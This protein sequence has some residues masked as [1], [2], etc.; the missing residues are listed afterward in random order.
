MTEQS[1][2]LAAKE[3]S[4]AGNQESS[5][6]PPYYEVS[7]MDLSRLATL[8]ELGGSKVEETAEGLRVTDPA[9]AV[10]HVRAAK[11]GSTAGPRH[12]AT[13]GNL[14]GDR[15]RLERL[16]GRLGNNRLAS[17]MGV[18]R[19]QP[20]RWRSGAEG[21]GTE[22]RRRLIDLDYAF[23]RLEQLFTPRQAGIWLTS[24]NAHLGARPIDVLR[25]RG[26][27]P[28]IAAID[29]EAEGAIA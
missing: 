18:S 16:V 7:G 26:V 6:D 11:K 13:T 1:E 25:V 14:A 21:I 12:R 23:G 27:A 20:S 5:K 8:Y 28:V 29:A 19:S 3:A 2:S 9:G 17:L 4:Q 24:E 15:E 10:T 22:N